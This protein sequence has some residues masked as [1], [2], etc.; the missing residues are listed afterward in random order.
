MATTNLPPLRGS[1]PSG[2]LRASCGGGLSRL[3]FAPDPQKPW[4][5][6]RGRCEVWLLGHT[7]AQLVLPQDWL[8]MVFLSKGKSVTNA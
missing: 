1:K 5:G 4:C 3:V 2:S 8:R 7:G 6:E